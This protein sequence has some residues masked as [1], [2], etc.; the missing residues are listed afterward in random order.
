MWYITIRQYTIKTM[1]INRCTI[2][3]F[4]SL[5]T[6]FLLCGRETY[7]LKLAT[8][9]DRLF[10]FES[11][12]SL[13]FPSLLSR[14]CGPQV[15]KEPRDYEGLANSPKGSIRGSRESFRA[16]ASRY[17]YRVPKCRQGEVAFCRFEYDR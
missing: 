4:A 5:T 14:V 7:S 17:I 15:S 8:L 11:L 13:L 2:L 10:F 16:S 9:R 3:D 6:F 1:T 12:F